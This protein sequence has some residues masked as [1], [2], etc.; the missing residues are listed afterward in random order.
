MRI[1]YWVASAR[2]FIYSIGAVNKINAAVFYA[3]KN[4]NVVY[5]FTLAFV[6]HKEEVAVSHLLELHMS[7]GTFAHIGTC[8]IR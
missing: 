1:I 8:H 2:N 3:I 6:A 5:C 4:C 7:R